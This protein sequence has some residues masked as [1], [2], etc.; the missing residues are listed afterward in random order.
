[1]HS[2]TE[3][4]AVMAKLCEK[5]HLV[6]FV[7]ISFGVKFYVQIAFDAVNGEN[8]SLIGVLTRAYVL[9]LYRC[10]CCTCLETF[11]IV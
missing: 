3:Y 4:S 9:Y 11:F 10:T 2:H 7:P 6:R 8:R 1:M 5:C